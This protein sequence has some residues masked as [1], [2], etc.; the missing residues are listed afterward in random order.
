MLFDTEIAPENMFFFKIAYMSS[1]IND[2]NK[3]NCKGK[4]F[5]LTRKAA[6]LSGIIDFERFSQENQY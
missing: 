4:M 3:N 6:V 5:Y 1:A 2:E